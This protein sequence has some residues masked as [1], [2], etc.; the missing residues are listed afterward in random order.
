M[1]QITKAE[2]AKTV[3]EPGEAPRDQRPQIAFAGRSN[4]GKSSLL[5]ILC[6]RKNLA[7][8]SKTPGKT[9]ALNFFLVNEQIWFTDLPGYGYAKVEKKLR[10]QWGTLV[11][12]YLQET[13]DLARVIQI[14]DSRH[15][16]FPDDLELAEWL[17]HIGLRFLVVLTKADKL[18]RG[19]E[20]QALKR[21]QEAFSPSAPEKI[22]LFS[23]TSGRGRD[24]VLRWIGQVIRDYRDAE[25]EVRHSRAGRGD[26]EMT[27]HHA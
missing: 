6:R 8:V 16:P 22:T 7:Q 5:N 9:K 15:P 1:L 19:E 21:A 23:A 3:F 18:S 12:K 10:E 13:R 25:R 27:E 2:F 26:E 24:E 17:S 14:V 11:E 4:V 20:A